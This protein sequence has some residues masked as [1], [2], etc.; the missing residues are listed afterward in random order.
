MRSKEV[1]ILA[2]GLAKARALAEAVEGAISQKWTITAL[3]LHPKGI[4][5][6]DEPAAYELK[7]GTYYYFKDI[8]K[9]N[10]NYLNFLK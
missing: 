4:I 8:E 9:N 6:C 7:V 10:L 2:N 3:Q 5:V 1:L